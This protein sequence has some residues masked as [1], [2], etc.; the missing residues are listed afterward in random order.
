MLQFRACNFKYITIEWNRPRSYGD[1]IV[2]GY[3]IYI[4]GKATAVVSSEQTAFTLSN[5]IPSHDYSFQVQ[6]IILSLFF[7]ILI[8]K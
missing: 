1:A 4:D 3:K 2:V 5:G 8:F 7:S 6:V